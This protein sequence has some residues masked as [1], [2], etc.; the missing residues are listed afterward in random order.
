MGQDL[1]RDPPQDPPLCLRRCRPPLAVQVICSAGTPI[2]LEGECLAGRVITWH[3]PYRRHAGWWE[4][5]RGEMG[6]MYDVQL[7]DGVVYRLTYHPRQQAWWVL[8][9]YD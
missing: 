3:G 7:G 5:N 6:E 1:P 8:G 2:R 4:P 9:W